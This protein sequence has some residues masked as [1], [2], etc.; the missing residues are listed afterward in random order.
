MWE[1]NWD[2]NFDLKVYQK[3]VKLESVIIDIVRNE[4]KEFDK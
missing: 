4:K 1:W 3:Y 2:E